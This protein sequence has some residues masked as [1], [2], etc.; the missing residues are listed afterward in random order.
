MTRVGPLACCGAHSLTGC[1]FS[2]ARQAHAFACPPRA[3]IQNNTMPSPQS[4]P[5]PPSDQQARRLPLPCG[6]F[7]SSPW[8]LLL[9]FWARPRR[10]S[11]RAPSTLPHPTP[12]A[13]PSVSQKLTPTSTAARSLAVLF[14]RGNGGLTGAYERRVSAAAT[15]G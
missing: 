4:P 1:T 6:P 11:L 10:S 14:S 8:A 5:S 3:R 2:G 12:R 9:A 13:A 7:I 15:Q